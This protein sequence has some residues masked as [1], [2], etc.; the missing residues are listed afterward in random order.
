[1]RE[2]E[3]PSQNT[4][5]LITAHTHHSTL[6]LS[7]HHNANNMSGAMGLRGHGGPTRLCALTFPSAKTTTPQ[8]RAQSSSPQ[9]S[10]ASTAASRWWW[11]PVKGRADQRK[12]CGGAPSGKPQ[13]APFA[14][15]FRSCCA[16]SSRNWFAVGVHHRGQ[17][18]LAFSEPST[19]D[20]CVSSA[21]TV[22]PCRG[23]PAR[24]QS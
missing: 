1:M 13:A 11:A 24:K 8:T 19:G 10:L 3:H 9:R 15:A 17:A 16:P 23:W 14:P 4:A 6:Q 12:K 2:G 21:S 20:A 5:A 7:L 18:W 22:M